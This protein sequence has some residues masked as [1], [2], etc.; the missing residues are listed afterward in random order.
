MYTKA[1]KERDAH[2]KESNTWED[3]MEALNGKN[4]CLTPWCN[5]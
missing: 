4:L 1:L 2:I 3:F 5:E